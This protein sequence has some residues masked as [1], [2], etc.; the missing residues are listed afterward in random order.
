MSKRLTI[1]A[2]SSL[3]VLC[4]CVTG[5]DSRQ[6]SAEKAINDLPLEMYRVELIDT[7][8]EIASMVPVRPHLQTRSRLQ[9]E[10]VRLCLEL[11][12]PSRA[13][14]F[15]ENIGD[16]R[17]GAAHADLALFYV[18]QGAFSQARSELKTAEEFVLAIEDWPKERVQAHIARAYARLKNQT[19]TLEY[20]SGVEKI[21]QGLVVRDL[22]AECGPD[23]FDKQ[24]SALQT[25]LSSD[26]FDVVRQG[27]VACT[28]LYNRFYDDGERRVVVE[29]MISDEELLETLPGSVAIDIYSRMAFFAVENGDVET[30]N[31]WLNRTD[32][33]YN[34]MKWS[35]R[36]GIPQRAEIA[37]IRARAGAHDE[38]MA[39][40]ES[41][42]TLFEQEKETIANIY[43][44]ETLIPVAELFAKAGEQ[45]RALEVYELALSAAVVNPNARPQAEDISALCLSLVRNSIEPDDRLMSRIRELQSNLGD[46]W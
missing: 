2:V 23:Y 1:S 18:E 15:L 45:G 12:Q 8:Y 17:R 31:L 19:K 13:S 28:E 24:L 4:V 33:L 6:T 29:Q 9:A 11:G 26:R 21:D 41:L 34:N 30:A 37:K 46:P 42:L 39:E 5:C 22:A 25:F 35:A 3:L 27:L 20:L 7:A 16:W 38:A 36:F 40:G 43:W 14:L 44:A 10:V 32:N